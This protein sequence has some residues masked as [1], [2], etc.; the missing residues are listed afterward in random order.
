MPGLY[1]SG[2]GVFDAYFAVDIE[3]V[4]K[5]EWNT[6]RI[7]RDAFRGVFGPP[8][9]VRFS[10]LAKYRRPED[11]WGNLDREKVHRFMNWSRSGSVIAARPN[12]ATQGKTNRDYALLDIPIIYMTL[13]LPT[14]G[15]IMFPAD[16]NHRMKA[17]EELG[18][19]TFERFLVPAELEGNYRIRITEL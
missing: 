13:V 2:A 12:W 14:G 17:R 15:T 19:L 18:L 1:I 16:G 11:A 10:E 5:L 8:E 3:G 4:P 6:T 9:R 7:E